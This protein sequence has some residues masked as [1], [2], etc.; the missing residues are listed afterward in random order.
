[1]KEVEGETD[2]NFS[3]SQSS[4]RWEGA[5]RRGV[6]EE[7]GLTAGMRGLAGYF[8]IKVE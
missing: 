6:G 5:A 7:D 1:M 8:L 4:Y 3:R 2:A